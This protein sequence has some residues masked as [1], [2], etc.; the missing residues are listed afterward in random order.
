MEEDIAPAIVAKSK[1]S[2]AGFGMDTVSPEITWGGWKMIRKAALR[3]AARRRHAVTT[4]TRCL[5]KIRFQPIQ[6]PGAGSA[7]VLPFN[8]YSPQR[9]RP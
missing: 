9:T 6:G 8:K 3:G 4:P 5:I 1:K 7:R 2:D